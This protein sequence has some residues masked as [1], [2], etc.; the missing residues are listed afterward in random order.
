MLSSLSGFIIHFIQ[1]AGYFGIFI[2]MTLES[3]FIPIPSEVTMSFGGY[4]AQTGTLSLPL[5]VLIGAIGNLAGSLIAYAIGY[6]L[7]ERVILTLINKYGKFILLT[8]HEYLKA[9]IMYK[10]YGNGITFFSRLLPAVRTFISLPAGLSEMN[11]LKFAL[12]TFLGSLL[13]SAILASIGY[14]LGSHWDS[15]GPIYNKFQLVIIAAVVM[16]IGYY[17]YHKLKGSKKK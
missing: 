1:S 9:V 12:F 16:L 14:Y 7:E 4:L 17:I 5:V 13:W 15:I 3:A 11:L 2:L 6:F 8:E 10:K